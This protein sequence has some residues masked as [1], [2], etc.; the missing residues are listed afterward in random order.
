MPAWQ[1]PASI[2]ALAASIGLLAW[3]L[4]GLFDDEDT[5]ADEPDWSKSCIG[6][7]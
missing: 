4:A 5:R 3:V 6:K 7:S 2:A 1:I